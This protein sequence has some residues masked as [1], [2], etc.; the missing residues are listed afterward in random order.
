M[1]I[2]SDPEKEIL[3]RQS[4]VLSAE[5]EKYRQIVVHSLDEIHTLKDSRRRSH[6]G[7]LVGAPNGNATN[8]KEQYLFSEVL[9]LQ[10]ELDAMKEAQKRHER[11][12][13][14][15]LDAGNRIGGELK[16]A[17]GS[18]EDDDSSSSPSSSDSHDD[19]KSDGD[20]EQGEERAS[21]DKVDTLLETLV[22]AQDGEAESITEHDDDADSKDA[23]D[24]KTEVALV[25]EAANESDSVTAAVEIPVDLVPAHVLESKSKTFIIR[26]AFLKK[27]IAVDKIKTQYRGY[28]VRKNVELLYRHHQKQFAVTQA[29]QY[30]MQIVAPH[31]EM[32]CKCHG[33]TF[34]LVLRV[35]KD[36]PIVQVQMH[37]VEDERVRVVYFHL[38]ETIALLPL[39]EETSI[40]EKA[41]EVEIAE[42]FAALLSVVR[43]GGQYK[44]SLQRKKA[45][46]LEQREYRVQFNHLPEGSG[47]SSIPNE[48]YVESM[49]D[50]DT[51][52]RRGNRETREKHAADDAKE[53]EDLIRNTRIPL[54]DDTLQIDFNEIEANIATRADYVH[55]KK[56]LRRMSSSAPAGLDVIPESPRS[57]W[58]KFL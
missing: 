58:S 39:E 51:S 14:K 29:M 8:L 30:K 2:S 35:S 26:R 49:L 50:E 32:T 34:R 52:R 22:H 18:D 37:G 41:S 53:L 7:M 54:A 27:K 4:I 17:S 15:K 21:D 20:V 24:T 38:F 56:T 16:E 36:P 1:R 3:R 33:L 46:V 23:A 28:L 19:D 12:K 57:M 11:K 6:H 10:A 47:G 45:S 43:I 5:V 9:K 40:L 44:F 42:T 55:L 31:H 25:N 13:K 48:L